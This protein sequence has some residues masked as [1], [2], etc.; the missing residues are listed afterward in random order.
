VYL[1]I[2]I[3]GTNKLIDLNPRKAPG[4]DIITGRILKEM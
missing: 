1:Q 3:L 2:W 4:Y